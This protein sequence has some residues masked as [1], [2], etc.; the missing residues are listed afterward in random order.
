M[1]F[2]GAR[3]VPW[4]LAEVARTGPRELFTLGVLAVAMGIAFGATALFGISLALGALQRFGV[5]AAETLAITQGL[6]RG[7]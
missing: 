6:R 5:S 3:A 4:L 7:D 2:V 1:V